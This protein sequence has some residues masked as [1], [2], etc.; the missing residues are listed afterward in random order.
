MSNLP[1][2]MDDC[3]C[4]RGNECAIVQ[5]LEVSKVVFLIFTGVMPMSDHD[6]ND[7]GD[8]DG[9]AGNTEPQDSH[10]EDDDEDDE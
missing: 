2:G 10:P 3:G 9:S 1:F 6:K 7:D 8:S 4:G 5:G